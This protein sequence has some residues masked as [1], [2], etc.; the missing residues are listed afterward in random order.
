MDITA[1]N[2]GMTD[3]GRV[4]LRNFQRAKCLYQNGTSGRILDAAETIVGMQVAVPGEM[5]GHSEDTA[6]SG[7][8][9][10]AGSQAGNGDTAATGGANDEDD[11]P[12]GA[13]TANEP[14]AEDTPTPSSPLRSPTRPA[15][16]HVDI[17]RSIRV[18][19]D[20]LQASS[21]PGKGTQAHG[22]LYVGSGDTA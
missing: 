14:Q 11:D 1:E 10:A 12:A 21:P 15:A 18:V 5:P 3:D 9:P 22:S 7:E 4:V 6:V 8:D 2:L 13:G 20:G 16:R 19:L 17:G